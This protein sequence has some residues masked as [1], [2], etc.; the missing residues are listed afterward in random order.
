[1]VAVET[2]IFLHSDEVRAFFT[3]LKGTCWAPSCLWCNKLS[4]ACP[5]GCSGIWLWDFTPA[6]FPL[7]TTLSLSSGWMCFVTWAWKCR[8]LG[9]DQMQWQNPWIYCWHPVLGGHKAPLSYSILLQSLSSC[10]LCPPQWPSNLGAPRFFRTLARMLQPLTSRWGSKAFCCPHV[11]LARYCCHTPVRI[12]EPYWEAQRGASTVTQLGWVKGLALEDSSVPSVPPSSSGCSLYSKNY[13]IRSDLFGTE[14]IWRQ[15]ST[16]VSWSHPDVWEPCQQCR[17]ILDMAQ[18]IQESWLGPRGAQ[19]ERQLLAG[20]AH[21]VRSLER[22]GMLSSTCLSP[23]AA[24]ARARFTRCSCKAFAPCSAKDKSF[25]TSTLKLLFS[26]QCPSP[27][28]PSFLAL[29]GSSFEPLNSTPWKSRFLSG[30]VAPLRLKEE[31][32]VI[33]GSL[34][35]PSSYN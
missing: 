18:S 34:L 22:Q 17:A 21:M 27:Q 24:P 25:L 19:S 29:S 11:F 26:Y 6:N 28:L 4:K 35:L 33:A 13:K 23:V 15:Q 32:A 5:V 1:M 16:E 9:Q 20:S 31:Q 10:S 7:W 12:W 8:E 30:S 3:S 14:T 2:F